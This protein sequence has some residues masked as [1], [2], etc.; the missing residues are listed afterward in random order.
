[1][2]LLGYCLIERVEDDYFVRIKSIEDYLKNKYYY[3]KT[4]TTQD[5]I[6]EEVRSRRERIELILRDIVF[7]NMQSQY[8]KKAKERLTTYISGTNDQT[9]LKRMRDVP[10]NQALKELYFNQLKFIMGKDWKMYQNIF[11][12]KVKFEQF[13]DVINNNRI[14]A[15]AKDIDEEDYAVLQIA[16]K[17]FEKALS[18]YL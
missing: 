12:D 10:F 11:P 7:H 4:A 2:H 16:F 8:G 3:E 15:H 17:Y 1:M 18:D 5:Q 14:D 6:R 13:F 9:Q